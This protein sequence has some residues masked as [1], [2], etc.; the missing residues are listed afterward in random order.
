[1]D[2]KY[3]IPMGTAMTSRRPSTRSRTAACSPACLRTAT[4]KRCSTASRQPRDRPVHHRSAH[5]HLRRQRRRPHRHRRRP[6]PRPRVH[7]HDHHHRPARPRTHRTRTHHPRPPHHQRRLPLTQTRQWDGAS[8]TQP[9]ISRF[10]APCRFDRGT[11]PIQGGERFGRVVA[12]VVRPRTDGGGGEPFVRCAL[13]HALVA[14]PR[15]GASRVG[16]HPQREANGVEIETAAREELRGLG[17]ASRTNG[18]SNPATLK[19][20][21]I[22]SRRPGQHR[23]PRGR[24]QRKAWSALSTSTG[25]GAVAIVA[26]ATPWTFIEFGS[27]TKSMGSQPMSDTNRSCGASDSA[28]PIWI[29]RCPSRSSLPLISPSSPMSTAI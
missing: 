23:E 17:R 21:G 15:R 5:H 29:R 25:G 10:E 24:S 14:A 22:S 20:T 16:K 8:V 2:T 9:P 26:R 4:S 28:T 12:R 19:P 7:R 27:H 11:E 18:M 6:R 1:M 3:S 13:C